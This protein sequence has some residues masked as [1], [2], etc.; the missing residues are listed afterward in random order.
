MD[1]KERGVDAPLVSVVIATYRRPK[2]LERALES[3]NQQ[4]YKNF[5]VIVVDDNGESDFQNMTD[6]VV[7]AI[8][9]DAPVKNIKHGV[10]K[11]YAAARNTGIK[12]ASGEFV[13][14]L[15]DDDE[16]HPKKTTKQVGVL[17]QR[18]PD[19]GG[20]I[21]CRSTNLRNDGTSYFIEP[22]GSESGWVSDK[23]LMKNFI[24]ASSK[25][26]F[27]KCSLEAVQGLDEGLPTRAD[28]DLFIRVA[29]QYPLLLVDEPLVS[30][31]IEGDRI[32]KNIEKKIAGWA[33]FYKKW[34]NEINKDKKIKKAVLTQM[35]FELSK[36]FYISREWVLSR[37]HAVELIRN[38]SFFW[39]G[40]ALLLL[41]VT[42][43][44]VPLK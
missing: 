38:N 31:M 20:F 44:R 13:A 43:V 29:K 5:E 3:V 8:S 21:Y 35:H 24:G 18:S 37:R 30:F 23:L 14:F 2:E 1:K 27:R 16:W 26:I 9:I 19:E 34:E 39:K 17:T 22:K 40:Y 41:S 6:E 33:R 11:G 28:H 36:L 42:K 7:Q 32:T 4:I 15:D 12:A 25:V 10:N